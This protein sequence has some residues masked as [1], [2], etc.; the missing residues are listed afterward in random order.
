M[1]L[2]FRFLRGLPRL[3]FRLM[4][5]RDCVAYLEKYGAL[6]RTFRKNVGWWLGIVLSGLFVPAVFGI[7]YLVVDPDYRTFLLM[8]SEALRIL[9]PAL[10]VLL[11]ILWF[12][13]NKARLRRRMAAEA[14]S[15]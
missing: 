10:I 1:D 6:E 5:G 13:G 8:I 7:V 15:P 3:V 11:Y 4:Y 14:E 2:V 12:R 9:F